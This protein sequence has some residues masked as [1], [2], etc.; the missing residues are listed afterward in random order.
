MRLMVPLL[1][2]I[3]LSWGR[4]KGKSVQKIF[5]S[6]LSQRPLY[7][8]PGTRLRMLWLE[9]RKA[10]LPSTFHFS[11]VCKEDE[12]IPWR[13]STAQSSMQPAEFKLNLEINQE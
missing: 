7:F 4:M 11:A 1:I 8:Q 12:R 3:G 2:E 6:E 10:V 5:S 9:T 13:Q